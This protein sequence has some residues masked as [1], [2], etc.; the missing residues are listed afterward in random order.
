MEDNVSF[1]YRHNDNLHFRNVFRKPRVDSYETFLSASRTTNF[2]LWP[3][4]QSYNLYSIC[5]NKCNL[6][7]PVLGKRGSWNHRTKTLPVPALSADRISPLSPIDCV[8]LRAIVPLLMHVCVLSNGSSVLRPRF[9]P[10]PRHLLSFRA[11]TM[12]TRGRSS[13]LSDV[14]DRHVPIKRNWR[15]EIRIVSRWRHTCHRG[16]NYA[17]A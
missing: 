11:R 15:L 8:R 16:K 4:K 2:W 9:F 7:V 6:S 3:L 1:F 17:K 14:K 10:I 5:C 12:P 13:V